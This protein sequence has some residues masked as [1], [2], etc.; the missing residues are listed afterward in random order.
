MTSF[1][2]IENRIE[3]IVA[4]AAST[5]AAPDVSMLAF[6]LLSL[7]EQ[8]VERWVVARGEAPTADEKEG[9]RLLALQRQGSKGDPSFNACRET[10]RE[11][12]Y[13][14]NLI[15]LEPAHPKARDRLR[16]AAM[17]AKHLVLFIGGKLETSDL[18][19]FCCSSK[20][21]RMAG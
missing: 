8:I 9:F 19:E 21:I 10:C 2:D 6:E 4:D 13:Y 20:P 16:L 11:L 1:D 14:F 18:G 12:A 15:T 5:A 17:V 7:G 3:R